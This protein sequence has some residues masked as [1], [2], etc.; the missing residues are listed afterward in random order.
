MKDIECISD[1][2]PCE[3]HEMVTVTMPTGEKI[4]PTHTGLLDIPSLRQDQRVHLFKGLWGSLISVGNLADIG[5]TTI[6]TKDSAYVVGTE[7][8]EVVLTGRRDPHTRLYM[9]ALKPITPEDNAHAINQACIK[10]AA[11]ET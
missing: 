4:Q 7:R 5:L 6:F 1:V 9:L 10:K 8:N 3:P 11:I 2:R